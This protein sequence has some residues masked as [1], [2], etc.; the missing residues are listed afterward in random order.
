MTRTVK[1]YPN[2]CVRL[3]A[4]QVAGT[5]AI[6]LAFCIAGTAPA[7]TLDLSWNPNSEADLAG[8]RLY[9]GTASGTYTKQINVGKEKTSAAVENLLDE[10]RYFF[11]VTAYN[12]RGLES[13]PSNEIS[14]PAPDQ[15][16][17]LAARGPLQLDGV[18]IN[19][20]VIAG[21]G[22][23][24]LLIRALS[25]SMLIQ[26]GWD[27]PF[28]EVHDING[29][30]IATN[31]NWRMGDEQAILDSGLA[32][33]NDKDAAVIVTLNAGAY[34]VV[35]R[36]GSGDRGLG[37]VEIYDLGE[38]RDTLRLTISSARG[39]ILTGEGVLI[40]GIILEAGDRRTKIIARGLGPSLAAAGVPYTLSDPTLQ[41]FDGNGTVITSNDDWKETQQQQLEAVG[42]AP[43]NDRESAMITPLVPGRYTAILSGKNQGMGVGLIE[44]YSLP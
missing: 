9:Y 40:G 19:G 7:R 26:Q 27:D 14:Y 10:T 6:A 28:L 17:S 32:P 41:L 13:R 38:A 3:S 2:R 20:F 24:K 25:L 11:A 16:R 36:D 22:Q 1:F 5:Y 21:A 42:V 18:L 23:K 4:L 29:R 30:T 43:S 31:D 44:L 12:D 15:L 33:T 39:S 34:T 37:L 8:Y 35:T